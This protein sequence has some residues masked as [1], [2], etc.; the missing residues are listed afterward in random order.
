[1]TLPRVFPNTK[2]KNTTGHQKV[3]DF[4]LESGAADS[5]RLRVNFR[6]H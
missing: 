5:K 6:V 1:M 3:V 4:L 2:I